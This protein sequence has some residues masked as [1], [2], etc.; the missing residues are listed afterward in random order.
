VSEKPEEEHPSLGERLVAALEPDLGAPDTFDEVTQDELPTDVE[1]DFVPLAEVGDEGGGDR[2]DVDPYQYDSLQAQE[3]FDSAVAAAAA[4]EEERAV[5]EYLRASKIA[6]TAHEWYVAAVACQQ[7]GD[8]LVTPS[9][10]CDLD[11]AF[12]MYRR[13]IAAYEQC[14]LF[15]EA[16]ELAYRQM[17]CKMRLARQLR[18]P[19]THR[20]ELWVFWAVAGFGYRPLRVVQTAVMVVLGFGLLFWLTHGAVHGGTGQPADLIHSIYFSGT[21]FTTTGY[22]DFLPA[23]HMQFLAMLEGFVGAFM[24]GLFV[25]VLANRLNKS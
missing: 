11:R 6:E 3:A 15:A 22:G 9:P 7:V 25:A 5:Q 17:H 10:P 16:R 18:L 19:L 2:A 24:V 21:T 23:P 12:R 20:I 13:A 4:G 14:G 1:A 8:F